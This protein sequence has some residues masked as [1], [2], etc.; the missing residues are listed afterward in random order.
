MNKDANIVVGQVP[1]IISEKSYF[2]Y[3]NMLKGA[4]S[5]PIIDISTS[6]PMN[7]KFYQPLQSGNRKCVSPPKEV[8]EDGSKAW[9]N[10]LVGYFIEKKLSFS[11]VNNIAKKI[12]GNYGLLEVLANVKGFYFFKFSDDNSCCKVLEAG[13]W[14]FVGRM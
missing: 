6:K 1:P 2:S 13:P 4:H 10:C 3:S 14:L 5:G 11:L 8:A 7:L 12:W 9:K